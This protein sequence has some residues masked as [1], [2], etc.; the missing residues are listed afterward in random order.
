MN[1]LSKA[2]QARAKAVA[3]L[4][5]GARQTGSPKQDDTA[6]LLWR[7]LRINEWADH[8]G[9]MSLLATWTPERLDDVVA[10]TLLDH[11]HWHDAVRREYNK[12]LNI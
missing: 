9:L 6:W 2:D 10:G 11:T 3:S 1:T 8:L 5:L 7:L 4:A 12:T